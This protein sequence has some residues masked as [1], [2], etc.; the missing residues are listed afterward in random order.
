MLATSTSFWQK[1]KKKRKRKSQ[2]LACPLNIL[3]PKMK[4]K[5]KKK[6][7]QHL[8][9][10]GTAPPNDFL[11]NQPILLAKEKRVACLLVQEF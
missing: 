5:L 8:K 2:H 4:K 9:K 3:L 1:E 6:V 7:Y 11:S 10:R